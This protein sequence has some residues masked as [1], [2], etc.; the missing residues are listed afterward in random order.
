MYVRA[1]VLKPYFFLLGQPFS[2][3]QQRSPLATTIH[4]R[5]EN[6]TM[7]LVKLDWNL[8][9]ARQ[10][11]IGPIL[12]SRLYT[13]PSAALCIYVHH[14]TGVRRRVG[15][16]P[17]QRL[18]VTSTIDGR[19]YEF[20]GLTNGGVQVHYFVCLSLAVWKWPTTDR[21]YTYMYIVKRHFQLACPFGT[22]RVHWILLHDVIILCEHTICKCRPKVIVFDKNRNNTSWGKV[23][24]GLS[25]Y[26]LSFH[27][28]YNNR[29]HNISN[30]DGCAYM[31]D[32]I[33][34]TI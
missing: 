15:R 27:S 2:I 20:D 11:R 33:I 23:R 10:I 34:I 18:P 14:S 21:G 29:A 12:S 19:R 32:N 6:R 25:E 30:D 31:H 28:T 24:H 8:Q 5:M 7:G 26:I 9:S 22:E 1:T 17:K 16:T 3:I 4:T 13:D